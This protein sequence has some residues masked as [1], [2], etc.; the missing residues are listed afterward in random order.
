MELDNDTVN[1][2][3]KLSYSLNIDTLMGSN[4][5]RTYKLLSNNQRYQQHRYLSN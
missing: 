2:L 5:Y 4:L 3:Q 1:T